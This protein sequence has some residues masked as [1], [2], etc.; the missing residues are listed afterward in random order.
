MLAAAECDAIACG[1]PRPPPRPFIEP[2]DGPS[3]GVP[4][5]ETPTSVVG[6]ES[7]SLLSARRLTGFSDHAHH[8]YVFGAREQ[9]GARA[10]LVK[11]PHEG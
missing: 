4:T 1:E 7:L 5:V 9:A 8:L 11:S 3:S 6:L 2:S 10:P